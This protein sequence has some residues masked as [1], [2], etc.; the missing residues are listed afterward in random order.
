MRLGQSQR[1]SLVRRLYQWYTRFDCR[2]CGQCPDPSH[3]DSPRW[4]EY[5]GMT[6]CLNN[7]AESSD[8]T[9][10]RRYPLGCF[11]RRVAR[12]TQ[13]HRLSLSLTLPSERTGIG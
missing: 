4:R 7:R 11:Q 9:H 10:C 3:H 8:E 12:W 13:P 1:E 2:R 5:P 6:P